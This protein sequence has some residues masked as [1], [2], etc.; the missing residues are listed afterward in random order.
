MLP[1]EKG[2]LSGSWDGTLRVSI[3][4]PSCISMSVEILQE[5]DL[6][7]GQT[8]RTYP[9][10]GAQIS[11]IA[12]RPSSHSATPTSLPVGDVEDA[13][14]ERE[15]IS[16]SIGPDF[17]NEPEDPPPETTDTPTKATETI[18]PSTPAP[19]VAGDV[20]MSP[21][22]ESYDP[23]FDDDAEGEE[24]PVSGDVTMTVTP[25]KGTSI[26]QQVPDSQSQV[27]NLA[28]PSMG[29]QA[30]E[31]NSAS[32]PLFTT[33]TQISSRPGV[34][35]I[36]ILSPTTYKTFSDDVLLT[37]S[38]DGRVVLIDRRAPTYSGTGVSRLVAGDKAP[39]WCM[40]A[41]WSGNGTQVLAGRRNGTIDIWDVRKSSSS[42]SSNLLNTLRT[43]AE[44]GPVSCIVA[45][46]DGRHIATASQDNVRLWNTTELSTSDDMA[47]KRGRPPFK[48]IAGHHGGIISSMCE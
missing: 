5:W 41:I 47:K 19:E 20:I 22:A 7:T 9:T 3:M 46:P 15:R 40:S 10:H 6:N 14:D 24:V 2:F 35:N 29:N 27:P 13:E 36:P 17:Y 42:S 23:L 18:D 4:T 1:S 25:T 16:V 8:V 32:T 28:L 43:P 21:K 30:S 39:P 48:I 38:M 45:F 31:S 12:L 37:S 34:S 44:S 33:Q 26:A 11:S